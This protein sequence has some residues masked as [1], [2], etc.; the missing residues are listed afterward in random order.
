[1]NACANATVTTGQGQD[2]RTQE[3]KSTI[4]G[5]YDLLHMEVAY[6]ECSQIESEQ[7]KRIRSAA[8][9]VLDPIIEGMAAISE[10]QWLACTNEQYEPATDTFRQLASF[11]K[12]ILE[13]AEKL[14]L[15]HDGSACSIHRRELDI[16]GSR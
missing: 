5:W 14:R 15:L 4:P 12:T 1:M 13:L 6:S 2:S 7:L 9:N 11:Q 16:A 3:I 10:L 8:D